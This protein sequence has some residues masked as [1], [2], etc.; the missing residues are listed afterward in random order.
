VNQ[1][2]RVRLL[3]GP[4][5]PPP[6]KRG[7]RATCLLRDDD[8][9]IT[10]WSAGRIAWPRC[11]AEG[12]HG[13]GSGLLL[14]EELAHAVRCESEAAICYWWGVSGNVVWRLRPAAGPH[15]RTMTITGSEA[16]TVPSASVPSTENTW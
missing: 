14:D 6:L 8:V 5:T 16:R 13:G 15:L 1:R 4:Y 3:H 10:G 9:L 11:R 12:T 7:D 2:E